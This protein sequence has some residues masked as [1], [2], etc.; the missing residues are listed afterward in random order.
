[1]EWRDKAMLTSFALFVLA[2]SLE[3]FNIWPLLVA[4]LSLANWITLIPIH[5]AVL[6]SMLGIYHRASK[7]VLVRRS[8]VLAAA[9]LVIAN[10]SEFL[11]RS[12][13]PQGRILVPWPLLTRT[14]PTGG[15]SIAIGS[16]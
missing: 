5:L 10:T 13:G 4:H 14:L 8:E 11:P 3:V 2:L 7:G 9:G 6:I 15:P 12:W 1:M 16:G